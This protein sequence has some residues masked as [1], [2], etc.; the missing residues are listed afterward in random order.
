MTLPS[1]AVMVVTAEP[2]EQVE[3]AVSAAWV[4]P[5]D[6]AEPAELAEPV[7]S[8]ESVEPVVPESAVELAVLPQ[9]AVPI[10]Y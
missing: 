6:Q 5:A 9:Q 2:V 8:V 10:W 4:E 7:E 3:P 1:E